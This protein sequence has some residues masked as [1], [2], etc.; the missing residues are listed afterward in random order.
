MVILIVRGFALLALASATVLH[1]QVPQLISYQGRVAVGTMNFEGTGQ[2]KF[3]LMNADGSTTYWSNDGTSTAGSQPTAAVSLT[4]TKGLY[5]VLLGDATLPNMTVVPAT[6]FT[7][8]DVRLRVWFNDGTNGSQLLTPDQRIAAVGYAMMAGNVPDG[9]ITSAKLA[10]GA[11]TSTQ[12]AS[13]A[14]AANLASGNQSGVSSGGIV[15]SVDSSSPSLL[16]AGY[17]K[18]GNSTISL[19]E[20][21]T[22]TQTTDT[23]ALRGYH[24]AVWTGT[25]MLVWGGYDGS[26]LDTGGRYNPA[27][28][29]WA[30]MTQTNVPGARWKQRTV[31]TGSE[32]IVWGGNAGAA[33]FNTGGR[34]NPSTD[35]WTATSTTNAP[36]N[37]RTQNS[38]VWTG[39]EM[40]VWGGSSSGPTFHNTGARYN[41]STDVW[42][43]MSTTNAPVARYQHYAVWTGT[44]M[45]VWG[46]GTGALYYNDGAR[47]NPTT[48]TW[49]AP[50][51]TSNAPSARR[52]SLPIAVWTGNEMIVWGGYDGTYLGDGARYNPTTDIWVPLSATAAPSGRA[53]H[54]AVWTG[55][56][57]IV[58]GGFGGSRVSTGA[59]YTP[60]SDAW[61]A[62]ST[63]NLAARADHTM[64]WTGSEGIVWGGTSSG[65]YFSDG[66]RLTPARIFYL[67]QRN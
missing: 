59:Y 53:N 4:V 61:T 32:M 57:M 17:T 9:A 67:Y 6:V 20:S 52:D 58:W 66:S 48:D 64:V 5:S 26:Y 50:I 10:N 31:W 41:P 8:A 37:G 54:G 3:A 21:W 14:A 23:P 63:S 30:A 35:V 36:S 38:A 13:G 11:V 62:T 12:L 49:S 43:A 45:I 33:S 42:T 51:A 15:L 25:E 1:A 40:I 27:T 28:N 60:T 55:D 47:Y 46:G 56:K 22:A 34:Y 39:T 2:F 7:N 24:C 65:S 44:E 18:F 16:S 29:S 19:G